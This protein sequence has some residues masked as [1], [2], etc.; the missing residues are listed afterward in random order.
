MSRRDVLLDTGPLV[1]LLDRR[2]RWHRAC[3][4]VWPE[5]SRCVTTEAVVTEAAHLVGR[6]GGSPA[7]PL[8]FLLAADMPILGLEPDG[9]QLAAKLMHKYQD[10]PMDYADATLVVVAEGLRTDRVLTLDRRG[11]LA[12]RRLNGGRFS[13]VPS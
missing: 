2:D 8:E 10:T 11:F 1:A 13:I 4:A 7:F 12:Y 3:L 6:G 9:H 5:V